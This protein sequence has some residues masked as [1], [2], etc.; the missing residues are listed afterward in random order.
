MAANSAN[1]KEE[2]AKPASLGSYARILSYGTSNGGIYIM[3]L[4]LVC[5]MASGVALPLMN[6]VFGQLVGKFNQYFIPGSGITE[7]S[8]K[9]SV[10]Q[11]SL[12]IV[13]LFIGKFC[14]TYISMICF[15][16]T[17]LR[18]SGALR[19]E[20]TQAL[21]S[22]PMS[23]LDE[24]SVGTVTHAITALS[25]TIQQSVS[26]RL[27]ILFQSFALLVAAYA[28][29]FRYSWAL[30]LV[31][32]AAIVFV[33]LGFSLTMPFLVKAQQSVDKADEKHAALAAEVF[34]SIRTVFALGA[35]QP[36]FKKYT[37]W[38]EEA[39]K[40]GLRMSLVS[41]VHLAMLFFAMYVSFSLAFW[42][43]LKLYREGHIAN[44]NTVITVFFS[45]LLVVT[46]LGGIAGPLMAISKAISASGAFF[47]VI[48]SKP[49]NI[50]GIRDPESNHADIVFQNVTFSYPTRAE[51][52]VLKGFHARFE[53][54]KTTALVGP[55]GSGKSTIVAL[56]ERWY[57]LQFEEEEATSGHIHVGA[58][59]IN[60][61]DVKWW[62]SQIGLVQQEPFL[63]NDSIYNNVAFGLIGSQWENDTEPVK[64]ELV[65]AACKQAFADEFI[66]RL[67]MGYSTTVGEG[68]I[69]LS[70]GQ[71]Q[72]IAIARS[73]V[74]QPQILILDEATSS[75]DIQGEKIVQA[76][77][78]RVS[79]DR[80]T[81]MIAHRLAT[82][83]RADKIIVMKDGQN[84]E[85]G[86]HK[87]LILK[88]GIYHSLVHAQQLEPLTDLMDTDMPVSISS[89]K[90]EVR[91]QAY[92]TKE[93]S[94]QNCQDTPEPE[95]AFGF[96]HSFGVL[97]Y[98]N[99]SH[100]IF[101][102]LTLIGA[103]GAGSGFSLQSWLFARLVQVFQFTGE[104]LVHAANFWA[105][106]FF[107]LALAMATFYF[108]LGFSSNSISMFVVSNAR[109][110][111]F[112][113]LLSKPVSYYDREENSSGT[114]ISRLSTDSKQLQ[115]M[116]GPTGVFPLISIF[117]IVGCVAISFAFGWKLAAVT[118][119]AAMPFLFFSAFMRIRYE[120]KF[121]SLNAEVYADSS[122]FATEAVRAFRTVTALT[123]EDTILKRYS[124]LLKD[125]RQ[126]A[127]RKAWYATLVFAFSDSVELCA[128][129]LA[130][131]YG[132][133]LLASHEYDPVAFFVVYIAIIQGGQSAGQFF[134]FGPNI[135]QAKA[136]ANRILAA[137]LPTSEQ[138]QH[139]PVGP[140]S[141]SDYTPRPSVELKNVSFQYSSREIPTFV[142]LDLAIESG[143]F[144]AFV[145]PSGCGK[146]TLVSLLERFYD[147]TQGCILF[148]GRDIRSI[149]LSSYRN[150][151][152]LVA[153]E[154]KLFEGTI[155]E[156]L[157]LGLEAPNNPNTED[158]MIQACKDAEIYDFIVSLPDGFL[159]ELGV[160]AQASLSGGQKQRICI[161][162]ALIR[163]PLLLL[164][165]EATSSLDSQSESLVQGA[166]ERLASKRNMT[167]IAV[168]HRLATI[169]KAD[170]IFVFAE[171]ALGQGS[172]VI[173]SGTH[174]ELLH[175]KGA[176]WQMC[177][178]Q[179][180][181]R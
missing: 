142:N 177:Q 63:F 101:Y 15:R 116:F 137:R 51:I 129:A 100:W 93:S 176:Y 72:R 108:M 31:V 55:S 169:Q 134:S 91:A 162:R 181:D 123:M 146:S 119:F 26:D 6:I 144:V 168:A 18:A 4:G 124:T 180:L 69:T 170:A 84:F 34:G 135:A 40:R 12:Y 35:E 13:Y 164:L 151:L 175:R 99:R 131:W 82:V 128:M 140:L 67:P 10:N 49:D 79:K 43:G 9:S 58:H 86:S 16:L 44:I 139:V 71:R 19:L 90:E 105:L 141:S 29:A 171:G 48:D 148:G 1:S 21:F 39:R 121:E 2:T 150:A 52:T 167:I 102:A 81:I 56:I 98:E 143:Q 173:E 104:K 132:G 152:S 38:V 60:D 113:N 120:I 45:V 149:E 156:N 147:C 94:D 57:Q 109:M 157:L 112:Y 154:P 126:K 77:L 89:Q 75:I 125:Q 25:N 70:G 172:R 138:L 92:T 161:A 36:L 37:L 22:L 14:L 166:M 118:F 153:Q 97:I 145:G 32:S 64:M 20:Y 87:E 76:A 28:I 50:A 106:M 24:M 59:N 130:F 96:F 66:D 65:T 8:F 103:I 5:A 80:T 107:V 159:T 68:G 46:I 61:L 160:N 127:T 174:N 85:E 133:Q 30:T 95:R 115:E 11:D 110:D 111:Y 163:K 62:R 78:D 74:N 47:G 27:A 42:F 155:R 122:K 73:I 41:G 158:Q 178:A 83:R 114:L 33:V 179:A 54:N 17:S 88:E 3:I 23:K 7:Q 117:N 165:D 53:R 136:S